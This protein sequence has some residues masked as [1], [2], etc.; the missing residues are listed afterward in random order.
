MPQFFTASDGARLAFTDEGEGLPLLCLAGLTRTGAD[1]DYLR[2]HL[3]AGIR[4]IRPDYRGRGASPWTGSATYTVPQEARD[5]LDLLDHLGVDRAAVLG[6]S[7]GGMIGMLLAATA[8]DRLR[9]L[10]LN[11]V[12]PVIERSGLERIF[13][14]VGRNPALGSHAELAAALPWLMTGFAGVP[15]DRWMAEARL[16]YAETPDG[17]RITYDPELREAF[18][19]AMGGEPPDLWPLFDACAGLPLALIRGANS[20]LLS[21]ATVAEMRRRRP[22]M[23]LTEVPGRAHIPFL[24]EPESLQAI[25][26]FLSAAQ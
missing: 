8:K 9:G 10:C 1:F 19:A 15:D 2:P 25:R 17:L 18:I 26:A 21:P 22:D 12:G 3:P 5:A 23:I 11:D 4:L 7:R 24:D 13:N 14:Y 6:T 16:H 20:D